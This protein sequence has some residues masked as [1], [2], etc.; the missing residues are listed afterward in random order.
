MNLRSL[1]MFVATAE[2][3]G[4]GRACA[5]LHLS[6]PAASRQI[7]ALEAEFGVRL[8]HRIGRNLQLTAEGE[9]LLQH[10]RR[11]LADTDFLT[12]RARALKSG[13]TGTLRVGANPQNIGGVLAAFLPRYRRR[14]PGIEFQLVEGTAVQHG[15][16][17]ERGEIHVAIMP[18]GD[19]R[20][21][22]HLLYPVHALA[23]V[24]RAH[25]LNKRRVLEVAELANERLLLP[26][27]GY[28]S[29]AWFE[30]ACEIARV[31][32]RVLL[33]SAAPYSFIDLVAGGYGAA[34][35]AST[36]PI[37]N[38][39]VRAIPLVQRGAS[40]GRWST[41]SWDPRRLMLPYAEKFAAEF[42]EFTR[43][44][45]PGREFTQHAPALPKPKE[46]LG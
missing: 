12:E 37:R 43:R 39:K 5:R 17:L 21:V 36:V 45:Y 1:R 7:H 42:V 26:A 31:K 41:I 25:R 22:G 24:S 10:S 13:H 8:F 35:V 27:H 30:A 32:P 14:H 2:L 9:D 15:S 4:L 38:P 11:L 23:V 6:Q 16:R 28:G 46:F 19:E 3:G 33:E 44:A 34:V 20:V 29:R 18:A 40:L